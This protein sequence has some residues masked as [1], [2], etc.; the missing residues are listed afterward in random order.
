[1]GLAK[2]IKK[3]IN[4]LKVQFDSQTGFYYY[5]R[6]GNPIYIRHPKHFLPT[7][8]QV[9]LCQ[10]IFF[11]YYTP[12]DNDFVLDLGAGY[13][14]EANY[15]AQ[16]NLKNFHYLGVEGQPVIYECLANS[17]YQLG[18]SFRCS[19][20][21]ISNEP[22]FF[23]SQFSYFSVGSD[24]Q[25]YIEIPTLKWHEFIDHYRIQKIDLFKMNI[26][27]AEK[28]ILKNITDFSMIKRFIISCHDFRAN[29]GEGEHYRSKEVVLEILK[30]NNY[31][32]KTFNYQIPWADDWIYAEQ[33]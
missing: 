32:I 15:L 28:N 8:E 22:V 25:A 16:L 10:R 3:R 26:E 21:V 29:C 11:H 18:A 5:R 9:W 14:E 23:K 27:G 19:P 20:Y 1:M 13:S 4:Y 12:Q 30:K 2:S 17:L 6:F 24:D 31:Q 33:K 7:D